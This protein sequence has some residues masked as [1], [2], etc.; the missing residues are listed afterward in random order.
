MRRDCNDET[1]IQWFEFESHY[2]FHY[3]NAWEERNEKGEEII[4]FYGGVFKN[5]EPDMKSYPFGEHPFLYNTE[6]GKN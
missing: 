5:F 3:V 6:N 4:K 2:V 1:K